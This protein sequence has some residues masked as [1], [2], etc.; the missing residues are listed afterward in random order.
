MN[1]A[2][3]RPTPQPA[4]KSR[5]RVRARSLT[6]SQLRDLEAE[7]RAERARLDRALGTEATLDGAGAA[8]PESQES[9]IPGD[10]D[11]GLRVALH[12][13]AHAHRDAVDAALLRLAD[14]TYGRCS[15]CGGQIPFGRLIVMPESERCVACGPLA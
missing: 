4:P 7:L 11:G 5:A 12:G 15:E 10:T 13:R 9:L 2:R 1:K 14:G 8:A 3:A 6:A